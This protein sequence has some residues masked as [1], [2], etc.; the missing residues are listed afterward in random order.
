MRVSINS[1]ILADD[2]QKE[3][4]NK[5]TTKIAIEKIKSR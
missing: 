5:D 3:A 2:T 1:V 4:L